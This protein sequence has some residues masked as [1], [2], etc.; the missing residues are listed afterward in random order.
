MIPRSYQNK[1]DIR[2]IVLNIS[3]LETSFLL[4]KKVHRKCIVAFRVESISFWRHLGEIKV[5]SNN[6]LSVLEKLLHMMLAPRE[7]GLHL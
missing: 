1:T 5:I 4:E 6:H 7:K 3:T 2:K